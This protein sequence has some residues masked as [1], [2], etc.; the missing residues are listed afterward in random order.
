M[1]DWETFR[2][3]NIID[4]LVTMPRVEPGRFLWLCDRLLEASEGQRTPQGWPALPR[5]LKK[6]TWG[7]FLEDLKCKFESTKELGLNEHTFYVSVDRGLSPFFSPA[8]P[9]PQP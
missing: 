7:T 9:Q 8:P 1:R 3:Q 2:Q 5:K 4:R 6:G